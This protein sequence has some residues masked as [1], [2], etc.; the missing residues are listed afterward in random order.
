MAKFFS[1]CFHPFQ[2][3]NALKIL[4]GNP[5]IYEF[6]ITK[7]RNFQFCERSIKLPLSLSHVKGEH[8]AASEGRAEICSRSP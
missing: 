3:F 7:L 5:S 1:I 8:K 2:K 4:K 6:F